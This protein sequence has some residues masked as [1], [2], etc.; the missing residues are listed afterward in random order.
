MRILCE[1]VGLVF[2][3][4]GLLT[5][6]R[7]P[8]WIIWRVAILAGQFGYLAAA[9]PL[10]GCAA[11][12]LMRP[13][14]GAAI[15]GLALCAAAAALLLQ[16]CA[17][18]WLIGRSLPAR[19][20]AAFGP[21]DVAGEPFSLSGLFRRRPPVAR[22]SAMEFAPG[23]KLDFYPAGGGRPAPC[24]IMV[25]GG[26]WDGG[27]LREIPAFTDAIAASGYAVADVSYR[28]AP[29][30]IWPAQRDDIAAAIAFLKANSDRLGIDAGRL[31]L[32]GR[33]AGGQI[34]EACAYGFHDP[35]IRG[36][37]GLYA[38]DDMRFAWE[39]GRP[40]DA[41]NSPHL[42]RQ[43]LGGTPETAGAAYDSASGLNLVTKSSPPTLL[44]HG[45]ID[46][47][48]WCR[49]SERLAARLTQ[50]AVPNLYVEL[51]WATHALEYNPCS[52]S[53]QL[54]SYSTA[55]FLAAVCR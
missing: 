54:V 18:A 17:Q 9:V 37:I 16:P 10:C 6:F 26:G 48:V 32:A 55:W 45:R 12:L 34:A 31:V 29:E 14:D 28:L 21:A 27:G 23:L 13:M 24:L 19:L 40:D 30:H 46:T 44:I 42:L 38:P 43:F 52:P 33:S 22:R 35:A 50:E 51:P 49:H 2:S 15:I 5:V 53:G 41:L 20:S 47:L 8:D 4:L 11:C 1:A 3:G 7:S 39:W 36:V 25:H